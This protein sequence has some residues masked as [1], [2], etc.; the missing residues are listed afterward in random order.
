MVIRPIRIVLLMAG[1]FVLSVTVAQDISLQASVDRTAVQENES[2]TYILRVQGS[3]RAEPDLTPLAADFDILQRSRNTSIQMT[4]GR[5]MQMTEWTLQLMA[6][7]AGTFT[8]PPIAVAGALSNPL[9]I[10]VLPVAVTSAVADIFLEVTAEPSDPYVQS[11]VVYTMTL[12][13]GVGTGRS[14]LTLP[15]VSGGEA[16]IEKLGQDREYQTV[17][18]GRSFIALERQY[19]IFPQSSGSMIIEPVVFE[20]M[21]VSNS[22]FSNVQRYRSESLALAINP[23]VAAPTEFANAS[24]IPA[25]ALRLEERWSAG[26]G[27]LMTGIPQTRTLTVAAEG[28]LETQL[29]DLNI[30]QSDSIRQYSDQPELGREADQGTIRAHRTERFAVLAQ[31]AGL[32]VLAEVELPWFNTTEERWEVARIP[33][34]TVDVLPGAQAL[35]PDPGAQNS[36]V[37]AESIMQSSDWIWQVISAGLLA[38]WLI[39]LALWQSGRRPGDTPVEHVESTPPKRSASRRLLRQIRSAC[40]DN[41]GS[42]ARELL[43][44]WGELRFPDAVA[45]SLGALAKSFPADL[46]GTVQ[47]LE[48][49]L[50][51]PDTGTWS[52]KELR[53]ALAQVDSVSSASNITSNEELLPLYR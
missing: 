17:L 39:T 4:G 15:E 27:Q 49:C 52:G 10:E 45:Q 5:T 41:D 26:E 33:A 43:L 35:S 13:R 46:A 20:A 14:S 11:Q 19:A 44:A 25:Q 51:G 16:I 22:G 42:L 47:D 36:E 6:R 53:V 7:Q 38:A 48:R 24:W 23:A 8:L 12:F 1:S 50:Y 40:D 2:F 9:E 37:P 31:S 30:P 32:H 21:V 3:T 34:K 28:V 29:P 18:G